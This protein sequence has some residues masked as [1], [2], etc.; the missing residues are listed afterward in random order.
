VVACFDLNVLVGIDPGHLGTDHDG[1]TI[2]KPFDPM[3]AN[4]GSYDIEEWCKELVHRTTPSHEAHARVEWRAGHP[5]HTILAV[6]RELD[7]DLVVLAWAGNL[8][9]GRAAVVKRLLAHAT[10]PLML[11]P[12]VGAATPD[13]RKSSEGVRSQARAG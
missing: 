10:T 13:L 3:F 8:S 4:H 11:V 2:A 6:E 5:A 9:H 12:V 1:V 7:P